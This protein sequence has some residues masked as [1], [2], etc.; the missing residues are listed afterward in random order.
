MKIDV[1]LLKIE[2]AGICA[3]EYIFLYLRLLGRTVP[4]TILDNISLKSLEDKGFIKVVDEGFVKR[5]KLAAM[6]KNMLSVDE[7]ESWI[8]EWRHI[9]P[10]GIKS[11][12]KLV[13][14]TRY[15]CANKM[16]NFLKETSY[17]KEEVFAAAKAYCLERKS[18]NF[19]YMTIANYFIKKGNDSPLEAWCEQLKE[20]GDRV[21]EHGEWHKEI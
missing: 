16:L 1:D 11:G 12:G 2:R 4:K 7:I 13:R 21:G 19:E 18:A 3:N 10:S 9:W 14:G 17:T 20:E 5:P 15:D 8:D 6:F